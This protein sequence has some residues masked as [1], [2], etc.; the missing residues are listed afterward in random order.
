MDTVLI[1]IGTLFL[2]AGIIGCI[3]PGIPGPPLTYVSLILLEFT[4]VEPFTFI[5]MTSWAILVLGVTALDYYVPVWGTKKFG[6]SKFGVWG[7]I[8][9][10][11]IG[12]FTGPIGII[13]MP[14]VGAYLG[15][16]I[17]GM[18]NEE[19]L[20]AGLGSFLG[21]VAGTLMKL[22]VSIIIAYYFIV[23][24]WKFFAF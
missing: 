18:R 6:G 14:F 4:A 3:I 21:F 15:E 7:S 16:L 17:G 10:L 5:F 1:I 20:R 19:A 8:I 2:L 9:G 23:E 22:A 24:S 13:V 12:L 11:L